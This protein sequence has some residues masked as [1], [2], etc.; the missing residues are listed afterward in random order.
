MR[1]F[2]LI[3]PVGRRVVGQQAREKVEREFDE[4][5]VIEAYLRWLDLTLSH[6]KRGPGLDQGIEFGSKFNV[7]R[8]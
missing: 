5:R 2:A 4:N 6:P 3:G 7:P 1:D 8:A